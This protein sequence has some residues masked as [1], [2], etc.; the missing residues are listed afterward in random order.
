MKKFLYIVVSLFWS[1]AVIAQDSLSVNSD[2]IIDSQFSTATLDS[3]FESDSILNLPFDGV[4]H[5]YFL[6]K[7]FKIDCSV[8]DSSAVYFS[9]SVY[10]VRLQSLPHAME[11]TYN[12]VVKSQIERYARCPKNVG[13]MLGIG[14]AYYFPMFEEALER[15]NVP[16]E[17]KYLPVIESALNAKAKSP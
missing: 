2:S 4:L 16:L 12:K 11:M 5:D 15:H 9:D 7:S 1:I 8:E 13:Y 3:I 17:L 10:M 6:E 14:N